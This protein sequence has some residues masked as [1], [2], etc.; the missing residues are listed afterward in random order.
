MRNTILQWRVGL[1]FCI[2]GIFFAGRLAAQE[3]AVVVRDAWVR[4]PLPSKNDA[5]L[6]AVIENHSAQRRSVVS[7]ATDAAAQ[8][9]LH[10]MKMEKTV[11]RMTP[12]A[13][14][15]IPAKGKTSLNPSGYHL[16]LFGLKTR[17]SVGDMINVTLKLDDGTTVPVTAAFRK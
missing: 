6:F 14:I 1:I 16:M 17:P 4:M 7:A 12:V 2:A 15:S 5:A 10:E 9:E 13:E 8:A 3:A 11:M